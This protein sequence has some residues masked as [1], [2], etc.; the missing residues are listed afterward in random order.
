VATGTADWWPAYQAAYLD[1]GYRWIPKLIEARL[2]SDEA[3]PLRFWVIG[4]EDGSQVFL[5]AALIEDA[6]DRIKRRLAQRAEGPANQR[7]PGGPVEHERRRLEDLRVEIVATDLGLRLDRDSRVFHLAGFE[8]EAQAGPPDEASVSAPT[9]DVANLTI[10]ELGPAAAREARAEVER[11]EG[12][13]PDL[14]RIP[15]EK[16]DELA[17]AG[18]VGILFERFFRPGTG[19]RYSQ[20]SPRFEYLLHNDRWRIEDTEGVLNEGATWSMTFSLADVTQAEPPEAI[21]LVLVTNVLPW[22]KLYAQ[23]FDEEVAELPVQ[24]AWNRIQRS[25]RSGGWI[26]IDPRSE[27]VLDPAWAE[28]RAGGAEGDRVLVTTAV[29]MQRASHHYMTGEPIPGA[30]PGPEPV[31]VN[32]RCVTA[33][34]REDLTAGRGECDEAAVAAGFGAGFIR[35]CHGI[36]TEDQTG[37]SCGACSGGAAALWLCFGVPDAAE[38]KPTG[39]KNGERGPGA[40]R[41]GSS[42]ENPGLPGP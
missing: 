28:S 5:L 23:A 36:D 19:V 13:V 34:A 6:V 26:L 22:L 12:Q 40:S 16:L 20:N 38:V 7:Q 9:H 21:D 1:L 39:A 24:R 31:F 18:K 25:L 17:N 29:G 14:R 32:T 30:E 11:V 2:G 10:S 4:Y 27:A 37:L 8:P 35:P 42:P 33:G 3:K 15:A 41:P